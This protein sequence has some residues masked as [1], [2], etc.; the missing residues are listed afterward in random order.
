[1]GIGSVKERATS[2]IPSFM[3]IYEGDC[4]IKQK[5]SLLAKGL[6]WKSYGPLSFNPCNK[7]QSSSIVHFNVYTAATLLSSPKV[8]EASGRTLFAGTPSDGTGVGFLY[9]LCRPILSQNLLQIEEDVEGYYQQ[10]MT[11]YQSQGIQPVQ[12]LYPHVLC[13][14]EKL[15]F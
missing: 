10:F 4:I 13:S 5:F 6:Y 7:W 1:M 14:T 9:P 3:R 2:T 8:A 15:T 11:Y 12:I